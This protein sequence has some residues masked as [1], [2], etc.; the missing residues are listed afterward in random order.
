MVIVFEQN[1]SGV[2][3]FFML[4]WLLLVQC[5][6]GMGFFYVN[7]ML[8][9]LVYVVLMGMVDERFDIVVFGINN[10][11]NMGEDMFYLGIVVV[12]IE[13][14]MFGVLV[15]VFL[16]VDKGWVQLLDVVC[17]VVEIVVYYF[18]YL[19]LGNLLLNV[20]ILNLLYDELKGW[21]VMC[22]GKCYLLQ[23]VICQIDLCG[24]LIYWIG[25]V[26]DVLDV[27]E[28]IDFYVV[29]NGFV[30]I[31]LLQ[32]DFMYMQMLFVMCEWVCVGGWVL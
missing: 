19:L 23:L 25:V 10:G 4:L 28:G 8:I 7:G 31:M 9:D 12:V 27:S 11:Q 29:V 22:F 2:L 3:N 18:V 24:E 21:K 5:V 15:I 1:C 32:F 6:V 26:G 30:L 20:N 16:L 14:I 13:G 17:V